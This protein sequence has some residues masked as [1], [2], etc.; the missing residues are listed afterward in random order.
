[1]RQ[2]GPGWEAGNTDN[3][4]RNSNENRS[5]RERGTDGYSR[6]ASEQQQW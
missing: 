4:E 1:M 6:K 3:T 2:K 5:N